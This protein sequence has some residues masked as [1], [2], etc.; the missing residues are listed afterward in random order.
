MTTQTPR[1]AADSDGKEKEAGSADAARSQPDPITISPAIG[2]LPAIYVPPAPG[3][4]S[5]VG[6]LW[7]LTARVARLAGR[8]ATRHLPHRHPA[9]R[10][11]APRHPSTHPN[12]VRAAPLGGNSVRYSS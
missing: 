1:P 4:P 12:A 2:P 10:D 8:W 9:T 7:H 6:L 5:P 3:E 11:G